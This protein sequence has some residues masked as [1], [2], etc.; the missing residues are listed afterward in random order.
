MR[1]V[2]AIMLIF[3]ALSTGGV[4][5]EA[6]AITGFQK[7]GQILQDHMQVMQDCM[8]EMY[9]KGCTFSVQE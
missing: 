3:S 9:E 4:G 7:P 5:T 6:L 1:M 8:H 2:V